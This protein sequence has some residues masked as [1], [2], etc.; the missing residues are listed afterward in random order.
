MCELGLFQLACLCSS[1][2][3]ASL[4]LKP[5]HLAAF[6]G[7]LHRCSPLFLLSLLRA[8]YF[9]V[10]HRPRSSDAALFLGKLATG[11]FPVS[12][13]HSHMLR[14][15]IACSVKEQGP[16]LRI[17]L[18]GAV[19]PHVSV[20]SF[21]ALEPACPRSDVS[22]RGACGEVPCS[23]DILRTSH[24]G[25]PLL[26][27]AICRFI[28]CAAV[29]LKSGAAVNLPTVDNWCRTR[30]GVI[31]LTTSTLTTSRTRVLR[32]CRPPT[33]VPTPAVPSHCWSLSDLFI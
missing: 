2:T 19:R 33:R 30:G 26:F 4:C 13:T 9:H 31:H 32:P 22:R 23:H 12:S 20:F 10:L 5:S 7:A 28:D 24:C 27:G 14:R 18:D 15:A 3:F 21:E 29:R 1:S 16:D 11:G 25:S 8:P 17:S 6:Y